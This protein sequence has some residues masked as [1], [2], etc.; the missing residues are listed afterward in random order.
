MDLKE[1]NILD[2]DID[3]H[4]YYKSKAKAME[5]LL[6]GLTIKSILDIGAGS[7]FFSRYLLR[8]TNALEAYCVDTSY[9]T[10]SIDLE[11]NKK[12]YFRKNIETAETKEADLVLLMDVLEHVDDDVGLLKEYIS[13]VPNGSTFLITVPAFNFLYG[14]HDVYLEHRRR[15]TL[16]QLEEVVRDAGLNIEKGCYFFGMVFPVAVVLRITQKFLMNFNTPNTNLKRSNFLVNYLLKSVCSM[17]TT[18][19][20]FNRIA[21]LTAFCLARKD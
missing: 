1:I 3:Q 12:I 13:K 16:N 5:R 18:I 2:E 7:A 14:P 20:K 17:E 19:M 4:W 21:G 11:N 15:Y 9:K 8:Q 10:N 6:N